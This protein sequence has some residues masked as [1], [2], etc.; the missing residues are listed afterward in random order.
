MSGI[1]PKEKIFNLY[2]PRVEGKEK[3]KTKP[4]K[5]GLLGVAG[6]KRDVLSRVLDPFIDRGA[7]EENAQKEEKRAVTK[8][9]LFT[10]GLSGGVGSAEKRARLAEALLL[11]PD[12]SANALLEAINLVSDYEEY[13]RIAKAL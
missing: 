6:M 5:A 1:L 4:S 13:K 10:D 8:L 7:C 2:I 9:D 3:R 11:P 12:M